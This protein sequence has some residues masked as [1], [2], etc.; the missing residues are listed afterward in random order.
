MK[1]IVDL[2][3]TNIKL[4]LFK[5]NKLA[6]VF[7]F[8]TNNYR[9]KEL[10][11]FVPSI[12]HLSIKEAYVGSVVPSLNKKII[13]E[14]KKTLNIN[15]VLITP[16]MFSCIFNLKRFN[17]NEIGVDILGYACL[18]K[19]RFKKAV[20]FS[21]GTATF[22]VAVNNEE[23]IGVVIAPAID[24][25]MNHLSKSTEMISFKKQSNLLIKAN[26][27]GNTNAALNAGSY[28]MANGFLQSAFSYCQKHYKI[29]RACISGGKIKN[30]ALTKNKNIQVIENVILLGYNELLIK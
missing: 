6:K 24:E 27:G 23:I 12:K 9:S 14:I 2:G 30:I 1:L 13:N 16:Q 20:G 17:L 19:Q 11:K 15:A 21:Y 22:A 18:L 25:G 7:T 4:G 28:H 26:F 8:S 3:N 10:I 29:N 5:A